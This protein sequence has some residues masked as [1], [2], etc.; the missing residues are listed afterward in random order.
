VPTDR[1]ISL[2][3]YRDI[4]PASKFFLRC[5]SPVSSAHV[6]I[7]ERKARKSPVW[8]SCSPIRQGCRKRDNVDRSGKRKTFVLRLRDQTVDSVN[9]GGARNK[10]AIPAILLFLWGFICAL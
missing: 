9:G 2:R 3:R 10:F 6:Q 1:Q 7:I 4:I 8:F 5:G